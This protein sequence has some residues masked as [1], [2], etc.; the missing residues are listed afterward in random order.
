LAW[1]GQ[2]IF[3]RSLRP[4]GSVDREGHAWPHSH[5]TGKAEVNSLESF[6]T[7]GNCSIRALNE[8]D[9]DAL[10]SLLERC[11]DYFRLVCEAPPGPSAAL[12]LFS[13]L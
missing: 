13:Q 4:E 1:P 2:K 7:T 5:S 9:A 11:N 12:A 3:R 6:F 8:L 10:Q